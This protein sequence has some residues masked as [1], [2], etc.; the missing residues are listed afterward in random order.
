MA[1]LEHSLG[2]KATYYFRIKKSSFHPAIMKEIEG[3]GHEVGYHYEN[4]SDTNGDLKS[5]LIDFEKHLTTFR[6][7]VQVKTISMHGR[8]LKPY[9]NRDLWKSKENHD[10]LLN[11]FGIL[12]EVYLDID[13]S[14]IAYV[15]DTGR[16]W[17]TNQSNR[18]DHVSSNINA[19]FDSSEALLNYFS[20][21]P[22]PKICFQIHPERWSDDKLEWV[23]QWA[24]DKAM[25]TIKK[26]MK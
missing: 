24:K 8:P 20:G 17:R 5:G 7:V 6:K 18:R 3:L 12:G 22:H 11:K 2:I 19:D 13:Y 10:V 1:K 25:N 21:N 15:N 4:L 23:T 26:I 9:D 14:D 16:N